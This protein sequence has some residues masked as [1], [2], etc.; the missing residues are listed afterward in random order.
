MQTLFEIDEHLIEEAIKY[1]KVTDKNELIK[2]VLIEFINNRKSLNIKDLKGEIEFREDY[3]Y[4][5]M[6]KNILK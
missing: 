2:I 3:D 4:K 5:E 1:A 6:R